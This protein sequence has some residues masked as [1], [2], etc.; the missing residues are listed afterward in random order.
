MSF[1][2]AT[3]RRWYLHTVVFN[4]SSSPYP[5]FQPQDSVLH[6]FLPWLENKASSTISSSLSIS[7]SSYG[8]SLFASKSIQTG[9]CILQVPYSVVRTHAR[10]LPILHHFHNTMIN[11]FVC[12]YLI[13]QQLTPDNLP[14]EIKPFISEDVGNVAKL[15]TVIL[16]HKKL[17]QVLVL[18]H[19][20]HLH[21][22]SF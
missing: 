17:G 11:L 1:R 15:A 13:L 16:I 2:V 9:D 6:N 19:T 20:F 5:Q 7:N 18:Y 3:L 10:T 22:T 12:S 8:N 4:F 14:P 21:F